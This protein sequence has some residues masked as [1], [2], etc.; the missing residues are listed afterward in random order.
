MVNGIFVTYK[1][2][3]CNMLICHFRI[4]MIFCVASYMTND[5]CMG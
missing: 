3:I 5:I 4:K 2:L 1:Y